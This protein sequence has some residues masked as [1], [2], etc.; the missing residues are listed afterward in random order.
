MP[1]PPLKLLCVVAHPDDE[2]FAFGGALALASD[3]DTE[4]HVL[5]LTDG[6]AASSR[7]D[8]ASPEDLARIRRAEFAASCAILGVT[9]H[10]VWDYADAQLEFADFSATAAR[11]VGLIRAFRPNVV[12]TFAP[13]GGPNTH[14]DHTVAS[15]LTSAAYHWAASLRRYPQAGPIHH[16]DR[17]F[18]QSHTFFLPNRPAPMPTPWTVTLDIRAVMARKQEAFAQHRSQAPLM[19]QTRALFEQFGQT[20]RYTLAAARDPQPAIQTQD[21]FAGL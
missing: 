6:Q 13:D 17:L 21:L 14:P 12:L 1:K 2:C 8:A 15:L 19:E 3:R 16:A 11:L 4:T 9:T 10:E 7:G 20:E 18:L 5:C